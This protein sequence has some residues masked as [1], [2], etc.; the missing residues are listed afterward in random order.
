V[1]CFEVGWFFLCE[2]GVFW[3]CGLVGEGWGGRGVF[4]FVGE[5]GGVFVFFSGF[6]LCGGGGLRGGGWFG[7][8]GVV[9]CRDKR[10]T[11]PM[12]WGEGHPWRSGAVA[13]I[14]TKWRDEGLHFIRKA[15]P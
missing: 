1:V 14:K 4:F 13:F 6:G 11:S 7:L 10:P 5:V 9:G 3:C 2:G 12:R 15:N 8:G